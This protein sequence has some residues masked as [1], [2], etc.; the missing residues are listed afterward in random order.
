[1]LR[2]RNRKA[3]TQLPRKR[4]RRALPDRVAPSSSLSPG[5]KSTYR[6]G[7]GDGDDGP[8]ELAR[9]VPRLKEKIKEAPG[10]R[11]VKA[12]S[13][14][15][16]CLLQQGTGNSTLPHSPLWIIFLPCCRAQASL[17]RCSRRYTIPSSPPMQRSR[18][19]HLLLPAASTHPQPSPASIVAS[20]A[21]A[22]PTYIP[23]PGLQVIL[24]P[25]HPLVVAIV[26]Y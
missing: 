17:S 4:K 6:C 13:E 18:R 25:I 12:S 7:N 16:E 21:R 3:P 14:E 9:T 11:K 23:T 8:S 26:A 10:E 5:K 19:A 22:P 1:M 24:H 15:S 2:S 20:R